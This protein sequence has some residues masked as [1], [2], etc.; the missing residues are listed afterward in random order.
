MSKERVEITRNG[1]DKTVEYNKRWEEDGITHRLTVEEVDGGYIVTENMYG[2]R[3]SAGE[4]SPYIDE[5]KKKVTTDNPLKKKKEEKELNSPLMAS[6]K[7]NFNDI[8][9]I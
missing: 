5:T 4:D 9:L 8:N 3:K 2:R 7:S 1:N 6:I